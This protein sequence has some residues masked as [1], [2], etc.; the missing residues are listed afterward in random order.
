VCPIDLDKRE[1]RLLAVATRKRRGEL[2]PE[3]R[4]TGQWLAAAGFVPGCK[5]AASVAFGNLLVT[6]VGRPPEEVKRLFAELYEDTPAPDPKLVKR[7][8]EDLRRE[9]RR[10]FPEPRHKR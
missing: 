7:C 5:L 6:I 10:R 3:I 1:V 8:V 2:V 9:Y 4:M